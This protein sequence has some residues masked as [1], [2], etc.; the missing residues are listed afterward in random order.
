MRGASALERVLHELPGA[1]IRVF[2]VWEPVL[3]LDTA[4]PTTAGLALVGDRRASQYWDERRLLSTA[5]LDARRA[6]PGDL[7][8]VWD[9]V[10]VFDP[11]V[12]W[13]GVRRADAFPAPRWQ[14][15]PVVD[16]VD[17][18]RATLRKIAP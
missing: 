17:E 7:G 11:G 8:I 12:R 2:V 9:W 14:G 5:I 1:S 3:L 13:P 10:A 18:L 6:E 4:P 15:R 16:V